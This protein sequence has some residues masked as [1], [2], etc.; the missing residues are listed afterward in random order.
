M[1]PTYIRFLAGVCVAFLF[2]IGCLVSW[3]PT[4]SEGLKCNDFV[5]RKVHLIL[6][7]SFQGHATAVT[8]MLP[9][10]TAQRLHLLCGH[11]TIRNLGSL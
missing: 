10:S 2:V 4:S 8:A 9:G 3:A 7:L 6:F 1:P 5:F 11:M